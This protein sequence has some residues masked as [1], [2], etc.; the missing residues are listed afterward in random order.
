MAEAKIVL[1]ATDQT[2]AA[3]ASAQ[4]NLQSIGNAAM[5]LPVKFAAIGTAIAAAFS[6]VS[7]K[8][9][10]NTLDQLDDLSE[11]TGIAVES[12]SMLRYA[13]EVT[14]TPLEAIA[15][16]TKKLATNMAEAA[17][18]NKE[19]AATFKAMGIE[20]KNAD[21]TLRSQDAVLLEMA[22]RFQ[23]YEDGAAKSALATKVFGKAG[24][25]MIPLLNQGSA[26]IR[27]LRGE[28]EQLG[29][30]YGG[31]LA[32]DAAT[33]N[34]NLK[35]LELASEGVKVALLGNI[36]GPLNR[37]LEVYLKLRGMGEI[38][39]VVKEGLKN[40][41]G[42]GRLSGNPGADISKLIAD[43]DEQRANVEARRRNG[44]PLKDS[45]EQL[46]YTEKLLRIA[47]MMQSVEALDGADNRD[48]RDRYGERAKEKAPT[49]KDPNAAAKAAAEAKREAE[50]QAKLLAELNGLS[51]SFAEDWER[52][53][54]LYKTGA[55]TLDQLTAAQA[56]LLEKQPAIAANA[57][58][59]ADAQK[60]LADTRQKAQELNDRALSQMDAENE[61]A[62]E[63]L[64]SLGEEIEE[65]GLGAEALHRLRQARMDANI[66][67][68]REELIR[69]QSNGASAEELAIRERSIALLERERDLRGETYYRQLDA[70]ASA[71]R[72]R[73]GNSFA[74]DF[75]AD[76]K[77]AFTRAFEAS[78]KPGKAFI[79]A[80]TSTL[81]TRL[82]QA[83]SNSLA[84]AL[85]VG[86]KGG[87]S[88]GFSLSGIGKLLSGSGSWGGFQSW[89]SLQGSGNVG[90]YGFENGFDTGAMGD[91]LGIGMHKGGIVGLD[92]T[93]TR[94][95]HP[96]VFESAP[97]Y[98]RGGIAGDEVP[99]ILQRGEEVIPRDE[100]RARRRG[101]GGGPLVVQHNTFNPGVSR[102]EVVAGLQQTRALAVGDVLD[103]Q[104]RNRFGGGR[105]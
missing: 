102:A 69:R 92:S 84:N 43:R 7:V 42:L 18:G 33:F 90:S 66:A 24:Q 96:A 47:R 9:A 16:G 72:A 22:D 49:V 101:S 104:R 26:G 103:G 99:A 52:L 17:S 20:V 40:S 23:G 60:S 74:S 48:P 75:E 15:N 35:K 12:L 14:G 46:A 45:E 73:A 98:H 70:D 10:I 97:R 65:I 86:G 54:A 67:A 31:A 36:L 50:A 64:R 32:R 8:G 87:G 30:V 39:T 83:L 28:A 94:P 21:G 80:F 63:R 38:G 78:E 56:K 62:A 77:G 2:R 13:G 88:G 59:E 6:A 3:F 19:A 91:I 57:K 27:A 95:V 82:A 53:S 34:D 100:V 41:I 71:E 76:L 58:A 37:I 55:L 25:E 85:G 79:A 68:E 29:L 105:R 1:S 44:A 81:Y 4:N 89:W 93:F 11:K 51:G 5:A 61:R